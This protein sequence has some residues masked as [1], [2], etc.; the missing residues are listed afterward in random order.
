MKARNIENIYSICLFMMVYAFLV[1]CGVE[2][3]YAEEQNK[4]MQGN[5]PDVLEIIS[6]IELAGRK[7]DREINNLPSM[8]DQEHAKMLSALDKWANTELAKTLVQSYEKVEL[9]LNATSLP[10]NEGTFSVWW[11][12]TGLSGKDAVEKMAKDFVNSFEKMA[13]CFHRR[14]FRSPRIRSVEEHL[15]RCPC[16]SL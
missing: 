4:T 1:L 16:C 12:T 3:A 15:H 6:E 11:K 13:S 10:E 5:S 7:I 14:S 9:E 8:I 2:S